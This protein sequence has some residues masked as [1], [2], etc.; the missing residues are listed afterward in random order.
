MSNMSYCRWENTLND[1]QDC[2]DSFHE[3]VSNEYETRA[4]RQMMEVAEELLR[5]YRENQEMVDN[6]E[7]NAEGRGET[8]EAETEG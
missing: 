6:E 8:D 7:L 3:G 2:V 1:L 4:R 5:L